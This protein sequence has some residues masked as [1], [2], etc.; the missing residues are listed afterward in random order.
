M[1]YVFGP[2]HVPFACGQSRGAFAHTTQECFSSITGNHAKGDSV[3]GP[4]VCFH[5]NSHNEVCT[6]VTGQAPVTLEWTNNTQGKKQN[7]PV[8]VVWYTYTNIIP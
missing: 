1:S 8:L 4:V 7:I 3:G 5:M 6:I 2:R